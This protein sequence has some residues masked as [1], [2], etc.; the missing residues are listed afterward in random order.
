MKTDNPTPRTARRHGGLMPVRDENGSLLIAIM[1]TIMITALLLVAT[2]SAMAGLTKSQRSRDYAAALQISDMAFADALMW[3]NV[4][5]FDG[6]STTSRTNSGSYA[7]VNWT[8][9]ATKVIGNRWTVNVTAAAKDGSLD[10]NFTATF[11]GTRVERNAVFS[12]T[13]RDGTRESIRYQVH[14]TEYFGNGFFG[15]DKF[16]ADDTFNAEIDGYNGV[17]GVVGS[18]GV[19]NTGGSQ[20]DQV[21]LWNFTSGTENTRCTGEYCTLANLKRYN[22]SLNM[23]TKPLVDACSGTVYPGWAATDGT[24]LVGGRCYGSLNF[25][26]NYT[27]PP[28]TDM[29]YSTGGI[30]FSNGVTVNMQ[31]NNLTAPSTNLRIGVLGEGGYGAVV[32]LRE[33]VQFAGAIYAPEGHCQVWN[34]QS[35]I[36]AGYQTIWLGAATCKSMSVRGSSRLRYDGGLIGV[37]SSSTAT[38]GPAV[39]AITDYQSLN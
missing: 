31:R 20:V 23:N 38:S 11:N 32:W 6:A 25:N 2:A 33:G 22:Q 16:S 17:K 8:W 1:F 19:V 7:N 5:L 3:A 24:H 9:T 12:D 28:L 27:P 13:D 29:I 10:R 37:K 14:E 18:N 21:N 30:Q 4:G 39:W 15:L 26:A 36:G 34:D 35:T